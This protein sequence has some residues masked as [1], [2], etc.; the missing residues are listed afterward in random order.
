MARVAGELA[1]NVVAAPE[2]LEKQYP[3][4]VQPMSRFTTVDRF[5]VFEDLQEKGQMVEWNPSMA[6]VVFLSQ[7]WLSFAH[8]DPDG[9]K[10]AVMRGVVKRMLR[11][12][13]QVGP[14]WVAEL[15][16][17]KSQVT[18]EETAMLAEKGYYWMDCE[19]VPQKDPVAKAKACNSIPYYVKECKYFIRLVP[20]AQHVERLSIVDWGVYNTR[21][22]CRAEATLRALTG[23]G[24]S[25]TITIESTSSY[26]ISMPEDWMNMPPGEG[27]FTVPEDKNILGPVLKAAMDDFLA[28][29]KKQG[30]VVSFR[31][32]RSLRNRQLS[33]CGSEPPLA[34]EE[35]MKAMGFSSPNDEASS[36]W[37]PLRFA[38]V[39]GRKDIAEELLKQGADVEARLAEDR[40]E[41]KHHTHKGSNILHT[42]AGFR[43]E[44][45]LMEFL[46]SKKADPT[47]KQSGGMTPLLLACEQVNTGN[48]AVLRKWAPQT[49]TEKHVNGC[50]ASDVAYCWGCLPD[51]ERLAITND[52]SILHSHRDGFGLHRLGE[53]LFNGQ[54]PSHENIQFLIDAKADVN[55]KSDPS[56]M[57]ALLSVLAKMSFVSLRYHDFKG[58]SPSDM[59][60][61]MAGLGVG[62]TPLMIASHF[63][64]VRAV[65]TFLK[66][67]AQVDIADGYKRT[68]LT[69]AAMRGHSQVVK[70]LLEN[71]AISTADSWNRM[72]LDWAKLREDDPVTQL[73]GADTKSNQQVASRSFF[74]CC[75]SSANSSEEVVTVELDPKMGV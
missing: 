31:M 33:G 3:M 59:S 37:T 12:R 9:I 51:D 19:S 73:L 42:L 24:K 35:W 18:S 16:G 4:C 66:A 72:P 44:P 41:W 30:D 74:A 48:A 22:W 7:T 43:D 25:P 29:S 17:D 58:T 28:T 63:G 45:D 36:G 68:A 56:A 69:I 32:M 21:G 55:L 6:P 71:K 15:F 20:P 23:F 11:K 67:G 53:T 40:P 46:I 14:G 13:F 39:E 64:N 1:E 5:S 34:Y 70:I 50:D 62:W 8:P 27:N 65:T 54:P 26:S 60:Q 57:S 10:H 61:L 75:A 38:A 49:Y 2:G 47:A 52:P